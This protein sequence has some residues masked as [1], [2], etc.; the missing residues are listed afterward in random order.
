[1][2]KFHRFKT[3]RAETGALEYLNR[4]HRLMKKLALIAFAMLA[5]NT[6]LPANE[7]PYRHVVLFK[8]KDDAAAEDVKKVEEA[9]VALKE[10]IDLITDFEWGTNE[11][12]EGL[13]EGFTHVYFVTFKNKADLEKY[14]PHPE[15]KAFVEI[16]KPQL[17]KVLVVDYVAKTK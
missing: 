6:S 1:M 12:P 5:L 14:L 7:A 8:F 15:H 9:F 4:N 2:C 3:M 13:D 10:K 11:S 16:L 17:D